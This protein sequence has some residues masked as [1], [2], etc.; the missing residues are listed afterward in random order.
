MGAESITPSD[1][2]RLPAARLIVDVDQF[3]QAAGTAR[4]SSE[5]TALQQALDLWTGPLLPEDQQRRLGRAVEDQRNHAALTAL[6]G[7]KLFEQGES[8]AALAPV[9]PPRIRPPTR[10]TPPPSADQFTT[11]V[12]LTLPSRRT[13]GSRCS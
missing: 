4:S 5:I 1:D 9:E 6:L 12:G 13:N 2:V 8:E 3:E 11:G 10:R 7:S